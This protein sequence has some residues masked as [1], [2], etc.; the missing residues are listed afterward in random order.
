VLR[1]ADIDIEVSDSQFYNMPVYMELEWN[2]TEVL[3]IPEF[4]KKLCGD[5]ERDLYANNT[6]RRGSF[7][8][9][10]VRIVAKAGSQYNMT[11]TAMYMEEIQI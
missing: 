10:K 4:I 6:L 9:D 3:E 2:D 11:L 1:L 7:R 8:W 5:V